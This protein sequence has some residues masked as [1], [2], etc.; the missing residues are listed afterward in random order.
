[1]SNSTDYFIIFIISILIYG[2]SPKV[3]TK[4]SKIYK[5]IDDTSLVA[6]LPIGS[7]VPNKA[8]VLGTLKVGD[9]GF[10]TNCD[11]KQNQKPEKLAEMQY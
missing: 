2:W 8:I 10:S 1:M 4:V 6:V 3:S 7:K 11:L 5:A 9:T